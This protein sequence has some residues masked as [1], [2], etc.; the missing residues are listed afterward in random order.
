M[1]RKFLPTLSNITWTETQP[2]FNWLDTR[3]YSDLQ[4]TQM[5]SLHRSGLPVEIFT[6]MCRELQEEL[7]KKFRD[8]CRPIIPGFDVAC[9]Y[10]DAEKET[11]YAKR[12]KALAIN[13]IRLEVYTVTKCL[14]KRGRYMKQRTYPPQTYAETLSSTLQDLFVETLCYAETTF[15]PD[16]DY[17]VIRDLCYSSLHNGAFVYMDQ[18]THRI[19]GLEGLGRMTIYNKILYEGRLTLVFIEMKESLPKNHIDNQI[20]SHRL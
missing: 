8:T 19:A 10:D 17:I 4:S 7:V 6:Q 3:L 20:L 9:L 11:S 2:F 16:L 13:L 18:T 1:R 15:K 14:D 12:L 5:Y